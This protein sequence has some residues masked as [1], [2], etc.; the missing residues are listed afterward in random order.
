MG[1]YTNIL[2]R[3]LEEARPANAWGFWTDLALILYA[4]QRDRELLSAAARCGQW[5]G[6]VQ[7]CARRAHHL[8]L[9]N[10]QPQRGLSAGCV[11]IV[12]EI[13]R[14]LAEDR[15][16]LE[17]S[18]ADLLDELL[19]QMIDQEYIHDLITPR[20]L[21][22]LMVKMALPQGPC[23]VLDPVCGSGRLLLAAHRVN[24]EA[25]LRGIEHRKS[26]APAALLRLQIGGIWNCD[27]NG[28]ADIFSLAPSL[29]ERFDIVLANPPYDGDLEATIHYIY[30]F[31][32][33]LKPCGRCAVLVPEGLLNHVVYTEALELRKY[34]LRSQTLEAVV[35]LPIEIYR[36]RTVSHS[37][38]L[39]FRKGLGRQ[40]V[41]FG[42]ISRYEGSERRFSDR[43]YLPDMERVLQAWNCWSAGKPLPAEAGAVCWTAAREA[44][45]RTEGCILS[46]EQYKPS[47]YIHQERQAGAL[48]QVRQCQCK[49]E[50]LLLQYMA[51][52]E[53]GNEM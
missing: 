11:L 21:A 4:L 32:K 47:V 20:S 51:G 42:R 16:T 15:P 37:S 25:S 38:L 8:P 34:L 1:R 45:E 36:P 40:E 13:L 35:S 9:D 3:L 52:Q 22:D 14:G 12:R 2:S 49:L 5:D 10:W 17:Q 53:T 39:L 27:V 19:Q 33:V 6:L 28:R 18:A 29:E 44:I 24:P 46:A 43:G 31:L 30:A 23:Q 7:Q 26:I 50:Y 48:D 41:F